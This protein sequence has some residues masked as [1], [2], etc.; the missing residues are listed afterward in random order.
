MAILALCAWVLAEKL[1]R[2]FARWMPDSLNTVRDLLPYVGLPERKN[3]TPDEILQ[4]IIHI[5]SEQ[6]S[7]PVEKIQPDHH[8]VKDL[9]VS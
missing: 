3:L 9:G 1:N 2:H 4:R 8:F 7:I 5:T 6:M